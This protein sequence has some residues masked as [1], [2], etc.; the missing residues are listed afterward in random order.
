MLFREFKLFY[1]GMIGLNFLGATHFLGDLIVYDCLLNNISQLINLWIVLKDRLHLK[2]ELLD[3]LLN[4]V[5]DL[6]IKILHLFLD[7]FVKDGDSPNDRFRAHL[8][9]IL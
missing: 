1:R 7:F 9:D 2:C 8:L 6:P 5:V 3:F 4:E